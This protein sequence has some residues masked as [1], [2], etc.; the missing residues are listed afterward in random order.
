MQYML[1]HAGAPGL[2]EAWN[3][4]AWAALTGWLDEAIGSGVSIE[5]SPLCLDAT[6]PRSGC[7]TAG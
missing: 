4:E 2:D 6:R 1:I 3:D 5:G 7:A